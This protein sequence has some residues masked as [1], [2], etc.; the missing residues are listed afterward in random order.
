MKIQQSGI[1]ARRASSL[2]PVIQSR[3]TNPFLLGDGFDRLI[4]R[5]Q[6]LPQDHL[7]S[8]TWVTHVALSFPPRGLYTVLSQMHR[9][10]E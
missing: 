1:F 6:H 8:F 4:I 3:F 5:R 10:L 7:F 2:A 9:A